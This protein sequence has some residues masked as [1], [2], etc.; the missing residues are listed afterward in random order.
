MM[1]LVVGRLTP[2]SCA[3]ACTDFHHRFE[4]GVYNLLNSEAKMFARL[5]LLVA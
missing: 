5:V 4:P 2:G 1:P 3:P